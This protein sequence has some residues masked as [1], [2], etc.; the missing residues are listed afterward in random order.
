MKLLRVSSIRRRTRRKR[1]QNL[2]YLYLAAATK[3]ETMLKSRKRERTD[4]CLRTSQSAN[5]A[6]DG[7]RRALPYLSKETT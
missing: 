3:K 2:Y 6:E 1:K 7:P 4:L 5:Q